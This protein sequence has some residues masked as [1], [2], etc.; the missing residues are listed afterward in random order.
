MDDT[1]RIPILHRQIVDEIEGDGAH[2]VL[3]YGSGDGRLIESFSDFE[4]Y[5][6]TLFDTDTEILKIAA[7]KFA[8][9]ENV[10]VKQESSQLTI[11]GYDAVVSSNVLMLMKT[12]EELGRVVEHM[13]SLVASGGSI[14]VGITHPCFLDHKF[15]TYS[16]DFTDGHKV[17][18]Y[19]KNGADYNVYMTVGSVEIEIK[20]H[21][22]N[23]STIINEFLVSDLCLRSIVE[24]PDI[25]SSNFSP[26]LFMK[27]CRE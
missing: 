18:D 25:Q 20:D 23:L 2:S 6:F 27:F 7:K 24:L 11:G 13:K 15:A 1:S 14:Y 22:W 12:R 19:F 4:K 5:K 17:F 8:K 9:N 3:D 16:N 21:F 10:T 26:F